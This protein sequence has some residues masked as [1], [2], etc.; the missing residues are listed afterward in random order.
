MK[1]NILASAILL[2]T[3]SL[4]LFAADDLAS[5]WEESSLDIKARSV[6]I[7]MN[8]N[9]VEFESLTAEEATYVAFATGAN[10]LMPGGLNTLTAEQFE[11][12]L[13][14]PSTLALVNAGLVGGGV[15]SPEALKASV[16]AQ[17]TLDQSGSAVWMQF[18]SAYMFDIIG[19]DLGFQGALKHHKE[20]EST[21]LIFADQDDESYSRLSSARV[22][23]RYGSETAFVKG[24][25]GI[26]S[27][28]DET[29]YL[30]D[31]SDQGYGV[32][33]HYNGLSLSYSATTATAGNTESDLV[34]IDPMNEEIELAYESDFGN[35]SAKREY[36][37]DVEHTDSYSA[38]SGLPLSMLGLNVAD[39][40]AMDYL[41]LA[42]VD[43][44]MKSLESDSDFAANQ[45]EIT[46]AAKI[47]G[48]TLAASYN[49]ASEDG[50]AGVANLV[51]KALLNDYDLPG[52][53][54]ITYAASFDGA[55]VNV[56]GLS[57]SAVMLNSSIDDMT[58]Q[59]LTYY[60]TGDAEFTETLVDATY[61]FSEDTFLSGLSLRGVFGNETNQANVSGYGVFVEY[62]RSF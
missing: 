4:P 25:Y 37:K 45:Y 2:S 24:H 16:E 6:L 3:A 36:T 38:A 21:M 59:S 33:G 57:V 20:D 19:F 29:D 61:S 11:A 13:A 58:A 49:Q 8:A 55:M 52:Q 60:L 46:L 39:G 62:N 18:E 34:D 35:A 12:A 50:G 14:D 1:K 40:K 47:D 54:T 5:F 9:D 48:I 15:P 26:Y 43:Y 27:E 28:A 32:S 53:T 56:P 41:L 17:G 10:A 7:Q 51:D 31:S 22:K 23:L 42:Q 44:A 30:M